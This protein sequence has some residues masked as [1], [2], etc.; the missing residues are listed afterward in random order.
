MKIIFKGAI[1]LVIVVS[2][3]FILG[4]EKVVF[5]GNEACA[6]ITPV[7]WPSRS[8]DEWACNSCP[9]PVWLCDDGIHTPVIPCSGSG[10]P[11]CNLYSGLCVHLCGTL[12]WVTGV[13][14]L[15]NTPVSCDKI[16]TGYC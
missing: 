8:V 14:N 16:S 3:I 4:K 7:C 5:A 15:L 10:D 13:C 9:E 1:F 12:G 2:C 11:I 6:P